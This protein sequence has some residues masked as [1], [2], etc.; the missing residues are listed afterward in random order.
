MYSYIKIRQAL[1]LR[2]M[3]WTHW[4]VKDFQELAGRSTSTHHPCPSQA[5]HALEKADPQFSFPA[6]GW[7]EEALP[8]SR[9]WFYPF[10][11]S[12]RP[13]FLPS[14]F[15]IL[16]LPEVSARRARLLAIISQPLIIWRRKAGSRGVERVECVPREAVRDLRPP[17][18]PAWDT[19]PTKGTR[20]SDTRGLWGP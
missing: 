20:L 15:Q 5:L 6:G 17:Q 19:N 3:C 9:R 10:L 4:S 18:L 2:F 1:L 12:F 11:W 8:R 13:N 16:K 14:R 7:D